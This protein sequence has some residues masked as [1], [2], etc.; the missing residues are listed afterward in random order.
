M[1]A[2]DRLSG[3]ALFVQ[4]A[5]AGSFSAAAEHLHLSRSA[6][7]K[8]IARLEARTGTQLFHRTT[9]S[10]SLTETGAVFYQRCVRVLEELDAAEEALQQGRDEA[11][12]KMRIS[13]PVELGRRVLGPVL[14]DLARRHPRLQLTLSYADRR[15]DLVEEG[16]DL[17]IRSGA[18]TDSP[19]LKMRKLG[20]QAMIVCAAPGYLAERGRPQTPEDL[21]R[22]AGLVYGRARN[23]GEWTFHTGTGTE[24]VATLPA[25]LCLDDL[26]ALLAAATAGLGI[27]RLP[28][29][30]ANGALRAGHVV[31]L[32]GEYAIPPYP[33]HLVWPQARQL[34]RRVRIVIDELVGVVPPLLAPS[35][36]PSDG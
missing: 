34:P 17:A 15:A 29:W 5:E 4:A 32:L 12:G 22:H 36:R 26:D 19:L 7:A 16:F 6:V 35:S 21:S 18:L 31:Q 10:Q 27:A 1:S 13:M 9:R 28:T 24:T 11:V 3:I 14:F 2:A 25:R 8:S 23:F 33:L 30:L 20:D